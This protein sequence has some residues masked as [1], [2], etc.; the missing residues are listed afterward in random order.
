MTSHI[1]GDRGKI[2]SFVCCSIK[3]SCCL[4]RIPL[5]YAHTRQF[6]VSTVF[7]SLVNVIAPIYVG[8][9]KD[10]V[11]WIRVEGKGS[12]QNSPELKNFALHMIKRGTTQFVID[13]ENCPVMDSTFMGTLVG[14]VRNQNPAEES[15]LEI[16]NAN[17]RNLQLIQNLGLDQLLTLD[18][19]GS[20]WPDIRHQI[21]ALIDRETRLEHIELEKQTNNEHVLEA[22]QH[23]SKANK[24]N[25]PRFHD[26]I[27]FLKKEMQGDRPS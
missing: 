16:L 12:F 5:A 20:Q 22:H 13:L 10:G 11:V 6:F 23:L 4:Q 1:S 27:E 7:I 19:D 3:K 15:S 14:I 18:A 8:Q 17:T 21:P 2:D 24:E 9:F 25:A 26:V